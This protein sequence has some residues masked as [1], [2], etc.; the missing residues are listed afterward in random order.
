MSDNGKPDLYRVL[1]VRRNASAAS[2]KK[3]YRKRSMATHPDRGGDAAEF[4]QVNLAWR[5]LGDPDRRKRYDETGEVE[6]N[7]I[8]R[9]VERL[10][11]VLVPLFF[12]TIEQLAASGRSPLHLDVFASM[13]AS[14][15]KTLDDIDKQREKVKESQRIIEGVGKKVQAPEGEVDFFA[16]AVA[17]QVAKHTEHLKHIDEQMQALYEGLKFLE[18]CKYDVDAKKAMA[19]TVT[20][21]HG[22]AWTSTSGF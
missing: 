5:I 18:R 14:L 21:N 1:G 9:E 20:G 6:D 17:Q 13:R 10:A 22:Y 7:P 19:A 4:Q 8:P 11:G 15:R 2:I 12:Q 16:G 3:A